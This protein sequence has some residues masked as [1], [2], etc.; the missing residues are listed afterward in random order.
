MKFEEE[1]PSKNTVVA[2]PVLVFYIF[3]QTDLKEKFDSI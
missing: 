1:I 2:T 3:K